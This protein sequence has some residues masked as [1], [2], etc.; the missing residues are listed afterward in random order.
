ME[1]Q[2]GSIKAR[3]QIKFEEVL[4]EKWTRAVQLVYR[5]NNKLATQKL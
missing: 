4:G 3:K 1:K 2:E 5:T